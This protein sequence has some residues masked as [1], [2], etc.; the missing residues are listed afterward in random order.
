MWPSRSAPTSNMY[1]SENPQPLHRRAGE[2]DPGQRRGC[3]RISTRKMKTSLWTITNVGDKKLPYNV[4]KTGIKGADLVGVRYEQLLPMPDLMTPELEEKGFRVIAGDFVTTEDGTGVVHTAPYFGADDFRACKAAGMPFIG[5]P[6]EKTPDLPF[7]LVDKQGKFVDEVPEFG[8]RYVKAEYY[9]AEDTDGKGFQTHRPLAHQPAPE[10]RQQGLQN[11]KIQTQLPA[12]LAHRQTRAVLPAGLV[13]HPRISSQRAAGRTEQN[14]QLETRQH[15]HRA[16]W[17][18]A[19]QF[20]GLEPEPLALLGRA[21][22][23]L[24]HGRWGR[25]NLYRLG[26]KAVEA[27]LV[28]AGNR[29]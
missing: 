23:D 28:G 24:A 17:R 1:K 15:G 6:N 14:H 26:D 25:G 9:S 13:V 20:A 16:F 22:A 8:G 4:A 7:P 19:R 10:R 3:P 11:R 27:G 29:K 5:M 21:A 2:R 18:L 12:L